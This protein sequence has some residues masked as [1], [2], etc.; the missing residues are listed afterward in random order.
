MM[1]VPFVILL[2]V[3]FV[4]AVFTLILA[5]GVIEHETPTPTH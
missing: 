5:M 4:L 1:V 3:V 2:F